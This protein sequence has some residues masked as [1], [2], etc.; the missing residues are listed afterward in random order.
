[1][2]FGSIFGLS[3]AYSLSINLMKLK[4][5]TYSYYVEVNVTSGDPLILKKSVYRYMTKVFE[6]K[7][8]KKKRASLPDQKKVFFQLLKDLLKTFLIVYTNNFLDVCSFE[9]NYFKGSLCSFL[10]FC[11]KRVL[12]S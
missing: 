9:R 10:N 5:C 12:A 3:R 2:H 4:H 1:M 8:L 6:N 7:Y 11:N